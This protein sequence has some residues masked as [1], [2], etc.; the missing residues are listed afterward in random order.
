MPVKSQIAWCSMIVAGAAPG[1]ARQMTTRKARPALSAKDRKAL[2]D[3]IKAR[4][5]VL[6]MAQ[7]DLAEAAGYRTL[8][9]NE[10]ANGKTPNPTLAL[11]RAVAKVLGVQVS[12]LVG[13]T[14][15]DGDM[16]PIAP[17]EE[18]ELAIARGGLK[19]AD[20]ENF[21]RQR[22]SVG[23]MPL[24]ALIAWAKSIA[25][26]KANLDRGLEAKGRVTKG[27]QSL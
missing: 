2:G 13:D 5:A 8:T 6:N 10:L 11:L 20:A 17:E 4:L 7:A 26:G 14:A 24:E 23:P 19:G 18:I 15:Y 27:E 1:H 25:S 9:I 22:Q 21:R 3:R 12:D 16:A